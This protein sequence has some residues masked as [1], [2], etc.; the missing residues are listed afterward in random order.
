[1][2]IDIL[3]GLGLGVPIAGVYFF[4]GYVLLGADR[5]DAFGDCI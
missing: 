1:M 5:G 4:V 2:V 3:I